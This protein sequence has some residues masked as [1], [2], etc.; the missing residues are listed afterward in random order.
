ML[1]QYVQSRIDAYY[2]NQQ[3]LK[4]S[5][6]FNIWNFN[7]T[8]HPIKSPGM[9][10][11]CCDV[12]GVYTLYPDAKTKQIDSQESVPLIWQMANLR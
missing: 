11:I 6:K 8:Y 3:I 7:N 10:V 1:K 5:K 2:T 12:G 9:T 4:T